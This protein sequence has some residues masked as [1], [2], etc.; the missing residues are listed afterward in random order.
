MTRKEA[1]VIGQM[2]IVGCG[3]G[4]GAEAGGLLHRGGRSGW[5][6]DPFFFFFK[7]GHPD[8]FMWKVKDRKELRMI[9]KFLVLTAGRM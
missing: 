3:K 7:S 2:S 5:I 6:L 9:P 1:A 4:H 8:L